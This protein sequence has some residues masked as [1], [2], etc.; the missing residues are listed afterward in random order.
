MHAIVGVWGCWHLG[1]QASS[2]QVGHAMIRLCAHCKDSRLN[3]CLTCIRLTGTLRFDIWESSSLGSIHAPGCKRGVAPPGAIYLVR[4]GRVLERV[5]KPRAGGEG[6][7][8]LAPPPAPPTT[9]ANSPVEAHES[10]EPWLPGKTVTPQ[11][12]RQHIKS[13]KSEGCQSDVF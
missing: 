9:C 12:L 8:T 7:G 4:W 10:A 13:S 2:W 1:I 3:C 5:A 11:A 6:A